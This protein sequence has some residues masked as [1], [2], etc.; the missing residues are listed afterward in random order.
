MVANDL[1]HVRETIRSFINHSINIEGLGDDENLF[2]SGIVNSLFAVQLTTFVERHFGLEVGTDD[3]DIEN[4]KSVNAT[5]AFVVR[6]AGG[7]PV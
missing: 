2:E 6:K 4:F 5:A 3:L 7:N 1:N